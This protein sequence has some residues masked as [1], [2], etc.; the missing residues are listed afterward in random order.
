MSEEQWRKLGRYLS[1]IL[2]LSFVTSFL[3]VLRF[4]T[5]WGRQP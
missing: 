4:L 1:V 3:T 5:E 2:S